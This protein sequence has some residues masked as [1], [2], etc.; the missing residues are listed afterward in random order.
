MRAGPQ[1]PARVQMLGDQP[2]V[3]G[4]EHGVGVR[5]LEHDERRG[6]PRRPFGDVGAGQKRGRRGIQR[7]P[8]GVPH[9]LPPP[10]CRRATDTNVPPTTTT[11]RVTMPSVRLTLAM[12]AS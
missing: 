8:R 2:P 11:P 7:V 5:Q 6:L 9:A 4:G 12:S 3:V 10:R 1:P